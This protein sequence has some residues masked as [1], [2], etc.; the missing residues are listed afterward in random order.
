MGRFRDRPDRFSLPIASSD[1]TAA[2][3]PVRGWDQRTLID[4]IEKLVIGS[5]VRGAPGD[6]AT[7]SGDAA[8]GSKPGDA[9]TASTA[10]GGSFEHVQ[11]YRAARVGDFHVRVEVRLPEANT[12]RAPLIVLQPPGAPAGEPGSPQRPPSPSTVVGDPRL[13]NGVDDRGAFGEVDGQRFYFSIGFTQ[14]AAVD[15]SPV[16]PGRLFEAS[17]SGS[18]QCQIESWD[19][20]DEV[21]AQVRAMD[22]SK[23]GWRGLT[24]T[25]RSCG[26]EEARSQLLQP[27]LLRLQGA[28]QALLQ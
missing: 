28:L 24:A 2:P 25:A 23:P 13:L 14:L 4:R 27:A 9:E 10:V 15:P 7:P 18:C 12:G 21:G 20:A 8:A 16:E 17:C 6:A 22:R 11:Q 1:L 19:H 5:A 26:C 3:P